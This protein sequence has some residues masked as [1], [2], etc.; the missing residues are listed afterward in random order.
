M[1]R[2][3]SSARRPSPEIEAEHVFALF[4]R[5]RPLEPEPLV[6]RPGLAVARVIAGQQLSAT[7]GAHE[8]DDLG[9]RLAAKSV[10]LVA[11]IDQQSPKKERA[12]DAGPGSRSS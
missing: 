2:A 6:E 5:A 10:P 3:S 8:L 12:E 11:L 7:R 4:D 1:A 9:Q